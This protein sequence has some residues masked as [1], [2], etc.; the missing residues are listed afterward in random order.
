[1]MHVIKYH[2]GKYAHNKS[3][4]NT[5]YMLWVHNI[6]TF[7]SVIFNGTERH[8]QGLSLEDG[9]KQGW[10]HQTRFYFFYNSSI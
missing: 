2:L 3:D 8:I 4:T 9:K 1:M 10:A 5:V 7:K 6:Y